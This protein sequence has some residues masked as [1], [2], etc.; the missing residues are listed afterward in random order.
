[1]KEIKVRIVILNEF[2]FSRLFF[3]TKKSTFGYRTY[4]ENVA[5]N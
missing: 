5:N 1:M 4:E 3:L 2:I